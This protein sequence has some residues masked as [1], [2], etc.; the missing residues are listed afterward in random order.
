M[1]HVQLPSDEQEQE[2]EHKQA[3]EEAI[4]GAIRVRP[5]HHLHDAHA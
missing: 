4:E 3:Q 2:Q 1:R 5:K